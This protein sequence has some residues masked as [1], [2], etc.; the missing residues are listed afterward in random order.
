MRSGITFH[1]RPQPVIH[2]SPDGR[3]ASS[4]TRLF[5]PSC[6]NSSGGGWNGAIYHDQMILDPED[7]G[8]WKLWSITI[9]EHYFTVVLGGR[10][11]G[12]EPSASERV[13][14]GRYRPLDQVP[15]RRDGCGCR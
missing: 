11:V 7:G 12:G 9:D 13:Q 2:V 10:L 15:A 1:W 8:K 6:S 5:Q 4:R 3:S 14:A